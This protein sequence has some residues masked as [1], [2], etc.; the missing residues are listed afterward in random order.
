ML[1]HFIEC[2]MCDTRLKVR[3]PRQRPTGW[4]VLHLEA[5]AGTWE[6]SF[7]SRDCHLSWVRKMHSLPA[8][9]AT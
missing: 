1:E 9:A 5:D 2:D 6:K 8:M 3:E 4:I 7:C